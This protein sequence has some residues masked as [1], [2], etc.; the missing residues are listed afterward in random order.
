MDTYIQ[1]EIERLTEYGKLLASHDIEEHK[2]LLSTIGNYFVLTYPNDINNTYVLQ[3]SILL[4]QLYVQ[5]LHSGWNSKKLINQAKAMA[6]ELVEI[7]KSL[8]GTPRPTRFFELA[9]E[10]GE[11]LMLLGEIDWYSNPK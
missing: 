4:H 5:A 10:L 6:A 8:D 3:V 11:A 7:I 9:T 2:V 1:G